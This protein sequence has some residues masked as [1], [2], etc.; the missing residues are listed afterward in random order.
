MYKSLKEQIERL[1]KGSLQRKTPFNPKEVSS[2][3][4][5]PIEEWIWSGK[6]SDRE[7]IPRQEG[8]VRQRGFHK[9]HG[10]TD[11]KTHP[12][13]GER[14]LL[15]HR[16]MG[17]DEFGG[18][19]DSGFDKQYTSSWTPKLSIAQE[20]ADNNKGLVLSSWIP[21]SQIQSSLSAYGETE[22]SRSKFI[23][24]ESSMTQEEH[25]I[26]VNPHQLDIHD[27]FQK[28]F[29]QTS[30]DQSKSFQ[31]RQKIQEQFQAGQITPEQ[32]QQQIK[33]TFP[34]FSNIKKLPELA[35]SEE[36]ISNLVKNIISNFRENL[37]NEYYTKEETLDMLKNL[38]L[39]KSEEFEGVDS[40][41]LEKSWKKAVKNA[42]LILGLVNAAH[43]I[44]IDRPIQKKPLE[45]VYKEI[46]KKIAEKNKKIAQKIAEK[47]FRNPQIT[48]D[49]TADKSNSFF[50]DYDEYNKKI[51]EFLQ[52][53]SLNESSGGKNLNHQTMRSGIH[54]GDTAIGQYGLMPNTVKEMSNRIRKDYGPDHPLSSYEKM[55]EKQMRESFEKNPQH[56]KDMARYMANY[57]HGKSK[58]NENE[59]SWRWFQGH[60]T[61]KLPKD[62]DK[63]DYVIKY[64]KHIN[65]VRQ[66]KEETK[67]PQDIQMSNQLM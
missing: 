7:K 67:A 32:K 41:V 1:E 15:L 46:D 28:P 36:Y 16:G 48:T 60:N 22:E 61:K 56:E 57:V 52:A 55:N 4:R 8:N 34:K 33:E 26:I 38:V 27:E 65:Q 54:K 43:Y 45:Q 24:P 3:I 2:E 12:E 53:I 25:E 47:E 6:Q 66:P 51:D 59:M 44:G 14:M 31:D 11:V 18:L 19:M 35:A 49:I 13:T 29:E 58:G 23:D 63:H 9:L 20:Q 40:D 62:W 21:E 64:N 10:L 42:A 30:K 37:N 50:Q 39:K 5:E 17:E